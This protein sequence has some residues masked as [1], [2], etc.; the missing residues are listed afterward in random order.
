MKK[1]NKIKLRIKSI[2]TGFF[3]LFFSKKYHCMIYRVK[4]ILKK[5]MLNK[6]KVKS[7]ADTLTSA[8]ATHLGV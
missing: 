4:M 7:T 5:K 8:T 3:F 2:T 1:I 6:S